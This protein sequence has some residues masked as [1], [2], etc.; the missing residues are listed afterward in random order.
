MGE[1]K[2][3][4]DMDTAVRQVVSKAIASE[5]VIDIFA[6]AG[7]KNPDISILSDEFLADIQGL[8]QKNLALEMLR[9]L[10]NDEIKVRSRKNVVEARSFR[11]MLQASILKYQNRGIETAEVLQELIELARKLKAAQ[12]RGEVLGLNESEVAFYDALATNGSAVE[13]LGDETLKQIARELADRIRRSATIDWTIKETVRAEM[14]AMVRR[15]LRKYKYP[16]DQQEAA[17]ELV[18]TQAE[19]LAHDLVA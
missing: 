11:E 9:K 10:I 4:E 17:T 14:R 7:L 1:K 8:P 3:V 18:L 6:Q 12:Q 16:P 15:L 13:V 2:T 5:G 19:T